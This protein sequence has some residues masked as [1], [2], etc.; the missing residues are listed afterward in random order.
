[1]PRSLGST[2]SATGPLAPVTTTFNAESVSAISC[3][4]SS[5]RGHIAARRRYSAARSMSCEIHRTHVGQFRPCAALGGIAQGGRRPR[6]PPA[7][8]G[9]Q[10]AAAA[11]REVVGLQELGRD[12]LRILL[13]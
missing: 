8:E 6:R 2:A 7:R 13:V 3:P 4:I 5:G 9:A 10:L 11:A 1:M 12:G